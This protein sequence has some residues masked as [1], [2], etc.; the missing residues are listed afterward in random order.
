MS[1]LTPEVLLALTAVGKALA[2]LFILVGFSAFLTF[3]E[4]RLLALWQD[5]YGPNRAG[6]FGVAQILAHPS[7][8]LESRLAAV[9]VI[10]ECGLVGQAPLVRDLVKAGDNPSIRRVALA[11][12]GQIGTSADAP[13]VRKY[14]DDRHPLV[15]RAAEGALKRLQSK[16]AVN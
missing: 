11:C 9:A 8:S 15:A 5:R 1:V 13:L 12:L 3:I 4:R 7:S 14:L 2:T 16:T 10:G 6:P